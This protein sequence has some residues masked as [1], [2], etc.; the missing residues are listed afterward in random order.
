MTTF[1]QRMLGEVV[2]GHAIV[3]VLLASVAGGIGLLGLRGAELAGCRER[4]LQHARPHNPQHDTTDSRYI[5]RCHRRAVG[6]EG[7]CPAPLRCV[8]AAATCRG[9]LGF[10]P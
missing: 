3:V 6:V 1:A 10:S 8:P 5:S 4:A 9:T 2:L 7:G